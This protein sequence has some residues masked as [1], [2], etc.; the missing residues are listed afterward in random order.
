MQPV[1]TAVIGYGLGGRTF[2]VPLISAVPSLDLTA[3][4]TSQSD[5]VHTE[6]PGI[7]VRRGAESVLDDSAID[8]VVISTPNDTHFD[9]ATRALRAGKHVVVDKPFTVTV[10]EAEGIVAAAAA[11][12][13]VLS[14]FHN[15][16]WDA[17]FLT[18]QRLLREGTLGDVNYIESHYDRC[19]PI[20]RDRWREHDVPGAGTWYDLGAHVVDQVLYLWGPPLA[21]TADLMAQRPGATATDYF[22]VILEYSGHRRAVLHGGSLAPNSSLRFVVHG[23]NGSYIK[24]GLDTQE[25]SLKAGEGPGSV[26]YGIDSVEGELTSAAGIVTRVHNE[27]GTYASFYED[28]FEAIRDGVRPP[29]TGQEGLAVMRIIEAGIRSARERRTVDLDLA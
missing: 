28:L 16:R 11:A 6:W 25:A 4:V 23:S 19:R 22:H 2:H 21:I 17:D 15:R 8:L 3:I 18:L 7:E 29:V 12:G 9:L 1:R 10:A 20:V 24:H 13:R 5:L 27:R 26:N 14:V